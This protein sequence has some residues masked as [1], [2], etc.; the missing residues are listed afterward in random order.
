MQVFFFTIYCVVFVLTLQVFNVKYFFFLV[1]VFGVTCVG[2]LLPWGFCYMCGFCYMW[3]GFLL[4]LCGFCYMCG[5][6]LYLCGFCYM[7]GFCFTCVGIFFTCVGFSLPLW[8]FVLPVWVLWGF[9]LPEWVGRFRQ[10]SWGSGIQTVYPLVGG[11]WEGL[12]IGPATCKIQQH[13][14]QWTTFKMIKT[15]SYLGI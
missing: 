15:S 9:N 3:C 12:Y 1:L 13:S 6:L 7:C 4:Y 14:A 5:F 10:S 11:S 2:I 8:V